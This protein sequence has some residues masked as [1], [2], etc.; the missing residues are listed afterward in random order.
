MIVERRT[1]FVKPGHEAEVVDL[2][3]A[4][5]EGNTIYTGSYRIYLPDIG[6]YGEVVVEWEYED[7]QE[8]RAAWQAWEAKENAAFWERWYALTERGGQGEIWKLAAER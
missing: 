8:M 3:K 5:I 4:G 6:P 1:F 7:L 2:I